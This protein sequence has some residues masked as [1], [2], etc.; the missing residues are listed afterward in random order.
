MRAA[1][2]STRARRTRVRSAK[3]AATRVPSAATRVPSAATRVPS[4]LSR[5][6]R[7]G[8]QSARA[9]LRHGPCERRGLARAM[10]E[11]LRAVAEHDADLG[12]LEHLVDVAF[13]EFGVQH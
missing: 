12:A 7:R 1:K 10:G 13:A 9:A 3:T 2:N 11:G 8:R 6:W 5:D 4:A